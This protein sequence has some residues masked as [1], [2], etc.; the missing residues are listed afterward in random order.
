MNQLSRNKY[1]IVSFHDLAPHSQQNCQKSIQDM[2]N[3]G[4]HK[5]S[6]LVVPKWYDGPYISE[7]QPFIQWLKQVE[8]QGHEICL[9]GLTHQAKSISGGMLSQATARLY[10]SKEG[11][12]YQVEYQQALD[13]LQSGIHCFEQANFTPSG[14]IAP[15][16]LLSDEGR[17][18]VINK[19]FQYTTY[20]QH[21]ETF[22]DDKRHYAPTLVFST[23]S[24]WRRW[25]SIYWTS[26]WLNYNKQAPILRLAI[27]PNDL[28]YP[29]IHKAINSLAKSAILQREC[30]T[31]Q[32][33]V[34]L[35]SGAMQE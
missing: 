34:R 28:K 25:M 8:D 4:I 19:G 7:N 11:E 16:W 22:P 12:F 15:A 21:L 9:H 27:H 3:I 13:M 23:R 10:T 2:A 32:E 26:F 20:L 17:K 5:L 14:F 6:L 1:F 18:A 24:A 30:I 33:F 35:N 31:Y 29:M